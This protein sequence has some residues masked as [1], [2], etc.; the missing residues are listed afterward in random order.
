MDEEINLQELAR[1]ITTHIRGSQE[2][3]RE[4]IA[5][6]F[7]ETLGLFIQHY[8]SEQDDDVFK[9][10]IPDDRRPYPE[11]RDGEF[12]SRNKYSKYEAISKERT[13]V[14]LTVFEVFIVPMTLVNGLGGFERKEANETFKIEFENGLQFDQQANVLNHVPL[15]RNVGN[16]LFPDVFDINDFLDNATSNRP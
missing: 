2:P 16:L 3:E 13:A 12:I 8:E 14:L 1:S 4:L 9:S 15:F 10:Y 5:Q 11:V 6:E 7:E